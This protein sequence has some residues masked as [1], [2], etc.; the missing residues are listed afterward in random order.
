MQMA[1]GT[2]PPPRAQMT[3]AA[4]QVTRAAGRVLVPGQDLIH[5]RDDLCGFA[6]QATLDTMGC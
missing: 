1:G 5:D 4:L 6:F 2:P 3:Q